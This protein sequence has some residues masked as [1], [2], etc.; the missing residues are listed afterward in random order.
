MEGMAFVPADLTVNLGDTVV[1]INRD[2]VQHTATDPINHPGAWDTGTVV[3]GDS[4][5]VVMTSRGTMEYTCTF[6]PVM[7]GKIVVE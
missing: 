4:G 7:T 2:I 1:W 3:A 6:H 5:V